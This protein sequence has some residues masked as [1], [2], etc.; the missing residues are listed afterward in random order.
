MADYSVQRGF[1]LYFGAHNHVALYTFTILSQQEFGGIRE[2]PQKYSVIFGSYKGWE[3]LWKT[4]DFRSNP[5][6]YEH[7]KLPKAA[8]EKSREWF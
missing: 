2:L 4:S 6:I 3:N 1:K 5:K 7:R 8:E